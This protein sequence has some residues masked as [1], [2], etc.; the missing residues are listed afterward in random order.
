MM[1]ATVGLVGAGQMG[2]ALGA[3]LR[4]GGHTVVTSLA[5][6]SARTVRFATA[7]GLSTVPSTV[8]VLEAASVVLVVTPP[9]EALA[10]AADLAS[11]AARCGARPLVADLNA[12]SPST[13]EAVAAAL[14]AAGLDL[15]DGAISGPPPSVRPGAR[16]YLSGQ[17]A[18]E[19]AGLGWCDVTIVPV[20]GPIGMASAVKMCTASVYKGVTGILTQALRVAA[21][22]GVVDHVLAD[23]GEAGYSPVQVASAASK[24][25][26]YVPEMREIAGTQAA[27]GLPATLFEVMAAI[28]ED[29]AQTQLAHRR[30]EEVDQNLAPEDFITLLTSTVRPQP[31]IEG[32]PC[33]RE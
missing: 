26:R 33:I 8:D 5:G 27:A 22:H 1:T 11:A 12:I 30:P 25:W 19:V 29:L 13:V 10:A 18:A 23:L 17:R 14:G 4:A 31:P 16:I 7:A 20:A 3:A 24:A 6:R 21:H 15:V 9:A 28:Y 2:S 32:E